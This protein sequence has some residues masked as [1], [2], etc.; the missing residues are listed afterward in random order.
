MLKKG[1]HTVQ[2]R[3]MKS[4]SGFSLAMG[5]QPLQFLFQNEQKPGAG[6][7]RRREEEKDKT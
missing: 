1:F 2:N 3:E 4:E 7:A 6:G 5:S